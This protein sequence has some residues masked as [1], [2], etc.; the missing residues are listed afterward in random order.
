MKFDTWQKMEMERCDETA[1]AGQGLD[2]GKEGEISIPHDRGDQRRKEEIITRIDEELDHHNEMMNGSGVGDGERVEEKNITD[3]YVLVNE[4]K[5]SQIPMENVHEGVTNDGKEE[6]EVTTIDYLSVKVFR[7]YQ[8]TLQHIS[9]RINSQNGDMIN[10]HC[11]YLFHFPSL[12]QIFIWIGKKSDIEDSQLIE[13]LLPD[14][15][16]EFCCTKPTSIFKRLDDVPP[17]DFQTHLGFLN[18][19]H[20]SPEKNQSINVYQHHHTTSP[21]NLQ[22]LAKFQPNSASYSTKLPMSILDDQHTFVI[23]SSLNVYIWIGSNCLPSSDILDLTTSYFP[24]S[25]IIQ[26]INQGNEP[27]L[28]RILF[29]DWNP[30]KIIGSY[31]TSPSMT[32]SPATPRRKSLV[33]ERR[34]S[35][36]KNNSV[37]DMSSLL[38]QRQ[39]SFYTRQSSSEGQTKW[40]LVNR[41]TSS[42]DQTPTKE[43]SVDQDILPNPEST[44]PNESSTVEAENS[45]RDQISSDPP[46]LSESPD[47]PTPI[48]ESSILIST[49]STIEKVEVTSLDD[50]S[51][52]IKTDDSRAPEMPSLMEEMSSLSVLAEA[53][54]VKHAETQD[55]ETLDPPLDTNHTPEALIQTTPQSQTIPSSN[56]KIQQSPSYS[57][58]PSTD[59]QQHPSTIPIHQKNQCFCM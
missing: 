57:N 6:H 24:S 3:E 58:P 36:T 5:S 12:E 20:D 23:E 42:D 7:C 33:A 38:P 25:K 22:L 29:H 52:Q 9:F 4:E 41:S 31:S 18:V 27:L 19:N 26:T 56:L 30:T 16:T 32:G 46:Q 10:S 8:H 45:I 43:N 1:G 14:L 35:F 47:A 50:S 59:E 53:D 39:G 44:L 15:I 28:F 48:E 51:Q 55:V 11:C 17:E 13:K 2:L 49:E 37:P 54:T 40:S 21:N 34:K